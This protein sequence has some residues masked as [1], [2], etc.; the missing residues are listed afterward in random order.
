[1]G[2]GWAVTAYEAI[3]VYITGNEIKRPESKCNVMHP[4]GTQWK[5]IIDDNYDKTIVSENETS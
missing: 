3:C 1:M 4:V 2:G 5:I